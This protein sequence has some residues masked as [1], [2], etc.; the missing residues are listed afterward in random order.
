M[1]SDT[2]WNR[3]SP[4]RTCGN[5]GHTG[6]PTFGNEIVAPGGYRMRC[7][8][9]QKFLGWGGKTKPVKD[10][11]NKRVM[12][13]QWTPK[14]LGIDYCQI[15]GRSAEFAAAVQEKLETHHLTPISDGGID[16]PR[17]LLV[18]C[19]GCHKEIHQRRTYYNDHIKGLF[20]AWQMLEQSRSEHGASQARGAYAVV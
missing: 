3:E 2:I 7:P 17:N 12:T 19:T 13:T 14:R 10:E 9:C 4:D 1:Y 6:Q 5:C 8:S 16:E 20:E 11:S 18:V 15:C